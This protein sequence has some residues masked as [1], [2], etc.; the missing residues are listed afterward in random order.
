MAN[1]S[2]GT[3]QEPAARGHHIGEW[4]WRFLSV[5]MLLAVAWA[6]WIF[7]QLSPTPLV[8]RAAFEA[9]AKARAMRDSRG[10]ITPAGNA[11]PAAAVAP[12]AAEPPKAEPQAQVQAPTQAP[13]AAPKEPPVNIEK[14]K[15]SDS[16]EKPLAERAAQK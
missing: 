1:D 4:F 5:V 7:Y 8:T 15:L 2:T 14:L 16:I 3:A 6:G 10:V 12:L 9:A 11:A 13:A